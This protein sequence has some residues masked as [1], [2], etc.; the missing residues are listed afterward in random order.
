MIL[1]NLGNSI[2]NPE[3]SKI[4]L[5]TRPNPQNSP[6]IL[7]EKFS[8]ESSLKAMHDEIF[9]P[10]LY[11][12]LEPI[13]DQTSD[14][15]T[16]APTI[17]MISTALLDKQ[18]TEPI[19][20]SKSQNFVGSK[21]QKSTK[22]HEETHE[23]DQYTS[24]G[25]SSSSLGLL[26]AVDSSSDN[27]SEHTNHK[28]ANFP[29]VLTYSLPLKVAQ[30][31]VPTEG[32]LPT[33][34]VCKSLAQS[35]SPPIQNTAYTNLV[36]GIPSLVRS[37]A[38]SSDNSAIPTD[39]PSDTICSLNVT[40]SWAP[41]ENNHISCTPPP[42]SS[43]VSSLHLTK[44]SLLKRRLDCNVPPLPNPILL[45]IYWLPVLLCSL[46]DRWPSGL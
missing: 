42:D 2:E 30:G 6:Y 28:H 46:Q 40:Q 26:P 7:P 23:S 19:L 32:S 22:A 31:W 4:S 24:K 14:L 36:P 21:S 39:T 37:F 35:L 41:T 5:L 1:K 15:P 18:I 45:D 12:L 20:E 27:S 33:E 44:R 3:C 34:K 16:S 8:K 38:E 25:H 17:S 10:L 9:F 43:N 11:R 13:K 29:L